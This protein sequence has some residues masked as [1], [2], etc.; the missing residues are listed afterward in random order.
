MKRKIKVAMSEVKRNSKGGG[1]K[2]WW[3]EECRKKNKKLERS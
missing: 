2:G 3:D 1:R